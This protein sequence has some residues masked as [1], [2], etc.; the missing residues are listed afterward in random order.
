MRNQVSIRRVHPLHIN[1]SFPAP[2]RCGTV[3][4]G[5][6]VSLCKVPR[7]VPCHHWPPP[8]P[9]SPPPRC[10][11][12]APCQALPW[13][14]SRTGEELTPDRAGPWCWRAV[15]RSPCRRSCP[16][17]WRA[18]PPP[19]WRWPPW[20]LW[21][22]RCCWWQS[23]R[24]TLL[25]IFRGCRRAA[26]PAHGDVKS[27]PGRLDF[28]TVGEKIGA[29]NGPIVTQPP[30]NRKLSKIKEMDLFPHLCIWQQV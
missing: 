23:P 20:P 12:A 5:L 14:S 25:F 21:C 8:P 16:L 30:L 3:C 7:I 24:V 2:P 6:F 9:W 28:S 22:W 10:I 13:T 15:W 18:R 1:V 29:P 27:S 4:L 19:P 17:S 26:S 11:T